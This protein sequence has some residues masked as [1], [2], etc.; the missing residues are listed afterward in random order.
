MG[1]ELNVL[2]MLKM[3]EAPD[4]VMNAPGVRY[5]QRMLSGNPHREIIDYLDEHRDVV[6]I[7]YDGFSQSRSELDKIR[8]NLKSRM[9]VPLI[10]VH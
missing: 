1:A 4:D 6:C 5:Y 8:K 10:V 3:K 2:Q 9:P 7:I